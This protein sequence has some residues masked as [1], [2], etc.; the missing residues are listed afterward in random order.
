MYNIYIKDK[1]IGGLPFMD[2]HERIPDLFAS[3]V[4]SEDVMRERL[5]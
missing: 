4:F 3:Q 1:R 2:K 5:P